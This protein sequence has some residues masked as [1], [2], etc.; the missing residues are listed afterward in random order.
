MDNK[1]L[2][3][4]LANAAASSAMEGLPLSPSDLQTVREILSGTLSIQ[5]VLREIQERYRED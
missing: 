4:A 2:E 3:K 5:E 1:N